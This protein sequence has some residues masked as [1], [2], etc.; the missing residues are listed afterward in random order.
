MSKPTIEVDD[1]RFGE[2][3]NY[4]VRY[5]LGRMS[6]AV[7]DTVSFIMPI[8]PYLTTRTI[9]VMHRD[10]KEQAEMN[11]LGMDCDKADWMK[12]YTAI[13]EELDKRKE[14]GYNVD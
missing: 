10:I 2:M 3:L 13:C 12:L 7:S 5:S 14:S 11:L 1:D 6:Y 9:Y 4:A 8:I